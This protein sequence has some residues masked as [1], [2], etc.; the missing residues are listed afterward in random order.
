MKLSFLTI[1]AISA[2]AVEFSLNCVQE[3]GGLPSGVTLSVNHDGDFSGT[4]NAENEACHFTEAG[5]EMTLAEAIDCNVG[6]ASNFEQ[7]LI[8]T[9]ASI[10]SESF[11]GTTSVGC[12]FASH[13][14]LESDTSDEESSRKRR[15]Y[16]I[17]HS[18]TQSDTQ[19]GLGTDLG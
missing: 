19:S 14:A 17:H 8:Y 1:S 13:Y 5:L 2:S 18:L 7:H 6:F 9:T 16:T 10:S 3:A 12:T 11:S 15:S 4:L